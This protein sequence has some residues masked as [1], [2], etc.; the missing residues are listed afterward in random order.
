LVLYASPAGFSNPWLRTLRA[1]V[2]ADAEGRTVITG[3]FHAHGFGLG[4]FA[5]FAAF[6]SLFAV[7]G[8]AVLVGR[9]IQGDSDAAVDVAPLVAQPILMLLAVW[10]LATLGVR[11]SIRA[12]DYLLRW[13][14]RCM[15]GSGPAN[16]VALAG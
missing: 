12:E 11:D 7:V 4:Y 16:V 5:A 9:L 1:R 3:G 15:A 13:L 6:V 10:A 14:A 2:Y 8:I